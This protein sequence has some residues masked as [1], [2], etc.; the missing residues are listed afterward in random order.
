MS[1]AVDGI[2][3]NDGIKNLMI[4]LGEELVVEPFPQFHTVDVKGA[5]AAAVDV[6]TPDGVYH[7]TLTQWEAEKLCSSP[8][9]VKWFADYLRECLLT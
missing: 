8:E 1:R 4:E 9:R 7:Y 3:I 5:A 6:H 2:A